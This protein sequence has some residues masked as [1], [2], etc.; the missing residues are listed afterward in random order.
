MRIDDVVADLE[1]DVLKLGDDVLEVL[2]LLV[3]RVGDGVLL[4]QG[5]AGPAARA[6]VCRYRSTRLIS[7]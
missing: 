7:C 3:G 4:L 5:A 6:Q 2:D 1:L